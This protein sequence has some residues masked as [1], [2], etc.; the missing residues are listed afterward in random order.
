MLDALLDGDAE[1]ILRKTIELAKGGDGPALKACLD[2]LLPVTRDRC[3]S[4]NVPRIAKVE[5]LPKAS[6]ALIAAVADG[7]ITPSEA[8]DV[9]KLV[10]IHVRALEATIQNQ[11][12]EE[13]EDKRL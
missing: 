4:F 13:L 12:L 5:D 7:E 8:S 3:V 1:T 11:R 2:R 6:A 10:D 9:A